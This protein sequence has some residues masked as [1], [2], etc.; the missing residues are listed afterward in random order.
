MAASRIAPERLDILYGPGSEWVQM[1]VPHQGQQIGFLFAQDGFVTVM[2]QHAVPY[3]RFCLTGMVAVFY[4][5]GKSGCRPQG[6]V[7]GKPVRF[8]RGPAAVI[9]DETR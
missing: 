1:D 9:G 8:R 3:L 5:T 7:K 2:K 6:L 4:R